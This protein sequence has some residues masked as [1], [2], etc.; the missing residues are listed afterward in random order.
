MAY[1]KD[2]LAHFGDY[3]KREYGQSVDVNKLASMAGSGKKAMRG[4]VYQ[5]EDDNPMKKFMDSQEQEETELSRLAK[6]NS[7]VSPV[8]TGIE[9]LGEWKTATPDLTAKAKHNITASGGKLGEWKSASPDLTR[10]AIENVVKAGGAYSMINGVEDDAFAGLGEDLTSVEATRTAKKSVSSMKD[11]GKEWMP[12]F[13]GLGDSS[14]NAEEDSSWHTYFNKAALASTDTGLILNLSKAVQSVPDNTSME[15][16]QE[17]Y[18]LALQMLHMRKKT[19]LRY[20]D[21]ERAEMEANLGWLIDPRLPKSGGFSKAIGQA[22]GAMG[23]KLAQDTKAAAKMER[24]F[25]LGRK[26]KNELSSQGQLSGLEDIKSWLSKPL[27]LAGLGVAAAGV[28][29]YYRKNRKKLFNRK[30]K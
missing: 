20:L 27:V 9:R 21:V 26:L 18:N 19:N 28:Y 30:R 2:S 4:Y 6:R 3:A 23:G 7:K 8:G 12:E 5:S 14:D 17:Y 22:V 1:H 13:A 11:A 15:K 24:R 16:R 25:A 10:R 29:C